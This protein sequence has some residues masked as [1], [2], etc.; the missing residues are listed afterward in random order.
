M[1]EYKHKIRIRPK[2][3]FSSFKKYRSVNPLKEETVSISLKDSVR[4]AQ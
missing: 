1:N 3:K 2:T 4:T